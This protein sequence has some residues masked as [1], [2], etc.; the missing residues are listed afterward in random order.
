MTW[1]Y[2][3]A[4]RFPRTTILLGVG[5]TLACTPGALRLRLRTDG[6]A[7]VP[8]NDPAILVDRE[9]RDLFGVQDTMV[10]A[11]KTDRRE[12][13]FNY[14]TLGIIR[15]LSARLPEIDGIEPED[16]TSLATEKRDRVYTGTLRFR[17]FLDPFP[18][19]QRGLDEI[20]GDLEAIDLFIGTLV[21]YDFSSSAILV[22]VSPEANRSRLVRDIRAKI[23]ELGPV[24]D[25]IS[26]VGAPAA[27]SL[28]GVHILED[29]GVLDL[30]AGMRSFLKD[31][32][33]WRILPQMHE[34]DLADGAASPVGQMLRA[35]GRPLPVAIAAIAAILLLTCRS[36][37]GMLLPLGEVGACLLATFGVMG[38]ADVPFYLTMA[39]LPV[40]LT[41][42]GVADEIHIF[43]RYRQALGEAA[44]EP[45]PR[46]LIVTMEE[47]WRPIMKTSVTSCIGFLS[48][49]LSPLE[50]VKMFGIFTSLGIFLC[51]LWSLTVIPA[52][53][54]LL[55][56]RRF[57]PRRSLTASPAVAY[58]GGRLWR[59]AGAVLRR[60]WLVLLVTVG[61]VA[62]APWGV[63]RLYVQDSWI[64][65]FAENS[66][67]YQATQRVN[68]GYGG[69]HLLW[70]CIEARP[71]YLEGEVPAEN[72]GRYEALLPVDLDEVQALSMVEGTFRFDLREM[73]EYRITEAIREAG[74][75]RIKTDRRDGLVATPETKAETEPILYSVSTN[76]KRLHN[77]VFIEAI[78]RLE[79]V[80]KADPAVGGVL[81]THDQLALM[82]FILRAREVGSRRVPDEPSTL[83]A[84]I[85]YYQMARGRQRMNELMTPD[86]NRT[87]TPVFLKNANFKD[88]AHVMDVIRQFEAEHLAPLGL[89]IRF[90]GDVAV[91]QA[92]IP[93]I[94]RTQVTSLLLSLVGILTVALLL[95]GS[96]SAGVYCVL[97]PALAVLLDYAIMGLAD[98]PLGVA[99]SMFCG[100]TLGIGVDY[101]IHL[102]ERCRVSFQRHSD[103]QEAVR[104]A[105][106]FAGP[107]IIIDA[108]AVA[109][110]FGVLILSRVP[111]NSRLGVL[112]VISITA[113]LAATL[114]LL[115]ALLSLIQPRFL[116]TQRRQAHQT[117]HAG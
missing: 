104:D 112:L 67:F 99:T 115:P 89:R 40:I 113:C 93:A 66:E 54:V 105:V 60:R 45:H 47:M 44:G 100:M 36:F 110:G 61:L 84:L 94:V 17:P 117:D 108:V 12:G 107:A 42:I 76:E 68:Q 4:I 27:E 96:L 53:L 86:H 59:A 31:H 111:A 85:R 25:R 51:M 72:L 15:D 2:R 91:S 46:A 43:A 18:T 102:I 9:V 55:D 21:S 116:R 16:I 95:F 57:R 48:F 80:L 90:A 26:V 83:G 73:H 8:K 79:N 35:F 52:A 5:L 75:V 78:G 6:H 92:M 50:P 22:S 28:L 1:I 23:A 39:V 19:D 13:I 64:N 56:P 41:A 62:A 24:R 109:V 14:E 58:G 11:V 114:L 7:L 20:R 30:L 71:Y 63:R 82:N 70:L 81:G 87:L 38:L 98:I 34:L 103:V 77:P 65:G 10:V 32:F 88:T 97:P 69:T 37:W 33:G 106:S 101:A 3:P 74:G 29:L 49:A